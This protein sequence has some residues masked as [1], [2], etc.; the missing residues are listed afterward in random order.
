MQKGRKFSDNPETNI[1]YNNSSTSQQAIQSSS[2]STAPPPAVLSIHPIAPP[3][4]L[5]N[6]HPASAIPNH[7]PPNM[8]VHQNYYPQAHP[9]FNQLNPSRVPMNDAIAFSSMIDSNIGGKLNDLFSDASSYNYQPPVPTI[10]SAAGQ[11]YYPYGPTPIPH[12]I[13]SSFRGFQNDQIYGNQANNNQRAIQQQFPQIAS[14]NFPRQDFPQPAYFP[15]DPES[16]P[17]IPKMNPYEFDE[18]KNSFRSPPV[19]M[20][21]KP[22]LGFYQSPN[23]KPELESYGASPS[24]SDQSF[25]STPGNIPYYSHIQPP[26]PFRDHNTSTST[27]ASSKPSF[28]MSKTSTSSH[29]K[30]N[31]NDSVDSF[32]SISSTK[33]YKIKKPKK[34]VNLRGGTCKVCGKVIKRDMTRHMRIHEE[35]SRFRCVYPRGSCIHKTGFFNRQYDFKKHLLHFHFD[36]DDP[37]VK[38]LYSLNEKLPHWGTCYCGL[39]FTGGEWLQSHILTTEKN[40]LCPHLA[41]LKE[42]EKE[43]YK[44]NPNQKLDKHDDEDSSGN[45]SYKSGA[46]H[47]YS[48]S[49]PTR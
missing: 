12:D 6:H 39:R 44:N 27:A 24:I 15:S 26:Y 5:P 40:H 23:P 2:N 7:N 31:R 10:S 43:D 20:H 1:P 37:S 48:D 11:T 42:K 46:D 45:E 14:H 22:T 34:P 8:S 41:R 30:E 28:S 33:S 38:K 9:Q 35:V 49:S 4:V 47:D 18:R 17:E 25:S 16:S 21:Y 13:Q 36:Y 32:N 3:Q 19:N 29:L